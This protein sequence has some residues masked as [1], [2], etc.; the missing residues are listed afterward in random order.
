MRISVR[1]RVYRKE[2]R[3]FVDETVDRVLYNIAGP[4]LSRRYARD[5]RDSRKVRIRHLVLANIQNVIDDERAE[6]RRQTALAE[7]MRTGIQPE[8]QFRGMWK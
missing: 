4:M 6:A 5:Y 7:Y 2:G 8:I 1:W 3:W